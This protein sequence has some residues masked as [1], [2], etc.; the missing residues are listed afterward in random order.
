MSEINVDNVDV[1]TK[2]VFPDGTEQTTAASG[3]VKQVIQRVQGEET[4]SVTV[5]NGW[6][7]TQY[8]VSITPTLATSKVLVSFHGTIFVDSSNDGVNWGIFSETAS[9]SAIALSAGYVDNHGYY[10]TSNLACQLLHS[11][12]A[13][14]EISYRLYIKSPYTTITYAIGYSY[15]AALLAP[16]HQVTSTAMEI[17]A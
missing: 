16:F 5:A 10:N 3:K 2:I 15:D 17:G 13:T 12:G 7:P 1:G 8:R 6:V 11:P 9:T 14:D 4:A